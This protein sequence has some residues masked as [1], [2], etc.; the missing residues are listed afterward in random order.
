MR[1]AGFIFLCLLSAYVVV[2][3]VV[4][5]G[6]LPLG[7]LV[8]PEMRKVF[9]AH[10]IGIYAHIFCSAFALALGPVQFWTR[11]RNHYPSAHRWVGRI[12]LSVGVLV[13]GA[14]GLFMAFHAFGGIVP[15]LGFACLAI[16]WLYT[17][18]QAFLAI[19]AGKVAEHRRWMVRNFGMTMAAVTL[20]IY[21]PLARAGGIDF[22]D[23][24]P[25]V[26]WLCWVPNLFIAELLFN[27]TRNATIQQST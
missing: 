20:R 14:A 16:A 1:F 26:A 4:A 2:Y 12:Y 13:G 9:E 21:L 15:R 8:Y 7:L 23:A 6:F 11:F 25:F 24:Y 5:Y 18:T 19:R 27:R 17:G 3:A 22:A 10:R